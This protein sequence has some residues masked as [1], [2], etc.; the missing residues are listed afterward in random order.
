MSESEAREQGRGSVHDMVAS[1]QARREELETK[2]LDKNRELKLL[3][4]QEAELTGVLP[5]ETPLEPG[6]FPPAFRRRVGTA[7]TYP[8]NLI[9]NNNKS[10]SKEEETLTALE[11]EYKVQ[12][13]IAEAALGLANDTTASKA[14]RR[15]HR[16]MYQ[17]SRRRLAELEA[18]LDLLRQSNKTQ[19][20]KQRKK[21][22]PPLDS[23]VEGVEREMNDAIAHDG[24]ISLSP[25]SPE[26]QPG[27]TRRYWDIRHSA[28]YDGLSRHAMRESKVAH[29]QLQRHGSGGYFSGQMPNTMHY[30]HQYSTLGIEVDMHRPRMDIGHAPTNTSTLPNYWVRHDYGPYVDVVDSAMRLNSGSMPRYPVTQPPSQHQH[31]RWNQE[32]NRF[33]SLDRRKAPAPSHSSSS[34]CLESWST[35]DL[36]LQ[37]Q[38]MGHQGTMYVMP[39]YAHAPAHPS[40]LCPSMEVRESQKQPLQATRSATGNGG[41]ALL[42]NQTYPEHSL[43]M[44]G[45]SGGLIR[46]QSLGSVDPQPTDTISRKHKEKEWYETS[47]DAPPQESQSR[48]TSSMRRRSPEPNGPT[49]DASSNLSRSSSNVSSDQHPHYRVHH[50]ATAKNE[51]FDTV[52]PFESPKNHTVVQAGKWQPYREVTKPFEMADFYKYSTKFRKSQAAQQQQQQHHHHQQTADSTQQQHGAVSPGFQGPTVCHNRS[53]HLESPTPQQKGIYQPLQPMTCQPLDPTARLRGRVVSPNASLDGSLV[54][55]NG[56]SLADAFSTEM[57]AWYQDQNIPRSATL[58]LST[59]MGRFLSETLAGESLSDSVEQQRLALLQRLEPHLGNEVSSTPNTPPPYLDM[60]GPK[61]AREEYVDAEVNGD[62]IEEEYEEF[63]S[64]SPPPIPAKVP[65]DSQTCSSSSPDYENLSLPFSELRNMTPKCGP[66]WRK[67][68][69]IFLDQWR[70]VWAGLYG[71]VV[72][73]YNSERDVKPAASLNIQGFDARPITTNVHKDPKKKDA[74]FEVVCPGRKTHQFIARTAKDMTQWVFAISQAGTEESSPPQRK[75]TFSAS[76]QLPS[77]PDGEGEVYDDVGATDNQRNYEPMHS[78]DEIYHDIADVYQNGSV[79]QQNMEQP[80]LPPRTPIP[81]VQVDLCPDDSVYDDVGVSTPPIV[82][83]NLPKT[84]EKDSEITTGARTPD[85]PQADEDFE[86]EEGEVI[87]DDI[88]VIEQLPDDPKNLGFRRESSGRIQH[89]IKQMEASIGNGNKHS[90]SRA[91][92]EPVKKSKSEELLYEP[93]ENAPISDLPPPLPQLPPRSNLVR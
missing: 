11:L 4:I 84:D 13:G 62:K 24:G 1:L 78:E 68:K 49:S 32:R 20:T 85:K 67:E 57:L 25:L 53:S 39:K 73:L 93:I 75:F 87:Y 63:P 61:V 2:L 31:T 56:E 71:H 7:F 41:G 92:P 16:L 65:P 46:T 10:K 91:K 6:E 81:S 21:P 74:T 89:L 55:G 44:D 33:G 60:N 36:E 70:R 9:N 18:K 28:T 42:P 19:Q 27:E 82:Y 29:P 76:R 23:D 52:V 38:L 90:A 54:L 12:T 80:P 83:S 58:V 79:I 86:E 51:T 14:V 40:V 64:P 30:M 72:L 22:R 34:P 5:P 8:E 37:S 69:F 47:L 48:P 26:V 15:K 50:V 43:G 17:Q 59:D 45:R 88:G 77:L 66:L 3:C 35:E